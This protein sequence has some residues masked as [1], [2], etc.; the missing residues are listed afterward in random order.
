MGNAGSGIELFVEGWETGFG[1]IDR[2]Y[3]YKGHVVGRLVSGYFVANERSGEIRG[4]E[5]EQYWKEYLAERDL[6]PKY[7]TR[8]H[9]GNWRWLDD[10]AFALLL[11]GALVLI[12]L[13]G[14]TA[15][16]LN[17]W[18]AGEA[19]FRLRRNPALIIFSLLLLLL[20]R[21]LL[22]NFPSSF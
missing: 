13:L 3:F 16:F 21:L 1:P 19:R 10:Y 22:D 6:V 12:P 15:R 11:I 14:A 2:W 20:F 5:E 7:W 18:I 9:T 8:W 4:F 17:R